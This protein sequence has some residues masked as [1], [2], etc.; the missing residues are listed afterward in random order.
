MKDPTLW[1]NIGLLIAT[2]GATAVAWWQAIAADRAR[3]D[4]ETAKDAALGAWRDAS[5]ALVRANRIS[6][7]T[8]RGPYAYALL[9]LAT[10]LLGARWVGQSDDQVMQLA[11]DRTRDI[12][13]K[14]FMV[15][16]ASTF[17]I[18]QWVTFYSR[19]SDLGARGDFDKFAAATDL[20]RTRIEM[21]FRDPQVAIDAVTA[22]P[23]IE[24]PG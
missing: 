6:D 21:W 8:L 3:K 5:D 4:S 2:A 24:I 11:M 12:T 17:E 22:D 1:L 20:V 19:F 7:V 15:G 10:A 18:T 9:E 23:R 14:G 16:D 13:E